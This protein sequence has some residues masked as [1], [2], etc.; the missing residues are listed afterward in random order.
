MSFLFTTSELSSTPVA[1][2]VRGVARLLI[3]W[4]AAWFGMLIVQACA[5]RLQSVS[6]GAAIWAVLGLAFWTYW[7]LTLRRRRGLRPLHSQ[8]RYFA[9]IELISEWRRDLPKSPE[10]LEVGSGPI[11]L[12]ELWPGPFTGCDARFDGPTSSNMKAV[13]GSAT[14]LPFPD[15]S[16]DLVVSVD[17]V[18]HLPSR[19]QRE[20]A[21]KELARVSRGIVI[22][23]FP[24]G[25]DAEK[26]DRELAQACRKRGLAVPAWLEEHLANGLP[27][28]N[29]PESALRGVVI[30]RYPSESARSHLW[31]MTRDWSPFTS[32]ALSLVQ[33]GAPRLLRWI[34]H[35]LSRTTRH[36]YRQ[37]YLIK[38]K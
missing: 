13:V 18:E 27:K 8:L 20:R 24:C 1:R 17:M 29:L 12:G 23:G 33:A 28:A 10:L 16:F 3:P 38:T 15:G 6:A 31:V 4:L 26:A 36:P 25:S 21:L 22:V 30:R 7:E 9:V 2:L 19:S 5:P 32:F 35:L 34:F 14:A 11:G 37:F